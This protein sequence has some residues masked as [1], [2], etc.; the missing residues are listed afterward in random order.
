MESTEAKTCA[1][2]PLMVSVPAAQFDALLAAVDETCL[3]AAWY[4]RDE[5]QTP[6]ML[7]PTECIAALGAALAALDEFDD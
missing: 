4:P 5:Y 1:N 2:Y 7:V 3:N 6:E